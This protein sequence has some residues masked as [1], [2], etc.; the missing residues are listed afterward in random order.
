MNRRK[1]IK[2]VVLL[3]DSIRR[4][5]YG[6]VVPELLGKEYEVWQPEENCMYSKWTFRAIYD[7]KDNLQ[8]ADVIHWNNGLWDVYDLFGDGTFSTV[9]EYKENVLRT[10]KILLRITPNVIFATTTPIRRGHPDIDV[11]DIIAFN[12]AVKSD[13]EKIGVKIND[14]YS[15]VEPH[16]NEYIREDDKIHLTEKGINAL[17]REISDFIKGVGK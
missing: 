14:L 11:N 15:F 3:G 6:T 1:F 13:L 12:N 5:G 7:W 10:A 8:G 2:K 4:I 9:E 17:G 16:I